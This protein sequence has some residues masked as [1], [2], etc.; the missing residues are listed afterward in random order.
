MLKAIWAKM[1]DMSVRQVAVLLACIGVVVYCSGLMNP[2]QNDDIPQI[3]DNP[4]V[5]SIG[6]MTKFFGGST[7]YDG[8]GLS[9]VYYRPLMT[10]VYAAI[11]TVSGA[12]P[13]A[14]HIVQLALH[15]AT[16]LLVYMVLTRFITRPTAL[17]LTLVFLV[18]PLNS[19]VVFSIPTMQD[20]LYVFCGM[21][22]MYLLIAHQRGKTYWGVAVLLLLSL[23]A[24]EA[25]ILFVLMA[26]IYQAL[27]RRKE[28]R[29]FALTLIAP[30]VLYI[31]MRV[32]AVGLM[33]SQHAGP[34]ND[35]SFGQR[36][37]T[38]PSV[39]LFYVV[40]FLWPAQLALTR[41]WTHT[42]WSVDG[43]LIP[44]IVDVLIV[45]L[46]VWGAIVLKA[47]VPAKRW[48]A[49]IF[50]FFWF[51][52]GIAPYLQILPGLDMTA[53]ETWMYMPM[54]GLLGLLGVV[55]EQVTW[56]RA[57]KPLVIGCV[58]VVVLAFTALG[59]RTMIRGFDY[60]SQA[61]LARVDLSVESDNYAALNNIAQ[62]Y[63]QKGSYETAITYANQSIRSYPVGSNYINLGVG[64]QQTH[65]FAEAFV[66]YDHA[67]KYSDSA[68][69]YENLALLHIVASKPAV[70]SQYF[71]TALHRYPHNF[72]LWLYDA[73]FEG[74]LGNHEA[75]QTCIT[76][77]A[78][79]GDV[80][81]TI[82][83]HIMTSTAFTVPIL[84]TQV[85]VH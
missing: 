43:V 20:V 77:A 23:L 59:V 14:Y 68:T 81:A 40:Q 10:T 42:T 69:I 52:I 49:Y 11:Y 50:F 3:V 60:K 7:F 48:L 39:G 36:L 84:G 55:L 71:Q 70:A 65:R 25:G 63:L 85:L 38:A 29:V 44:L 17:V 27:Y 64:L 35:L 30:V 67:L 47:R 53:C 74:A 34:I 33:P 21:W 15:I 24:K 31:T 13:F 62:D 73:V 72:K 78:Q 82:Y 57:K 19:Q 16:A 56:R 41:Y 4:I 1:A 26:L 22:A 32:G 75:A 66:A 54:I 51:V 58:L 45:G 61:N 8:E 46:L 9:G 80:P 6:N 12:Q 18:H 76:T 79:Y 28:L 5:H 83:Q 37:L 2:F